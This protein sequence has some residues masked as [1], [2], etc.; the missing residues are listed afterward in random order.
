MGKFSPSQSSA[1]SYP[2]APCRGCVAGLCDRPLPGSL[3]LPP[4]I[5]QPAVPPCWVRVR[6][7]G[8]VRALQREHLPG[9]GRGA[10]RGGRPGGRGRVARTAA[11]QCLAGPQGTN[12]QLPSDIPSQGLFLA[13][14]LIFRP[15]LGVP[16]RCCGAAG[17]AYRFAMHRSSAAEARRQMRW[18]EIQ[19]AKKHISTSHAVC[20]DVS[21]TS[22]Q[23]ENMARLCGT[24]CR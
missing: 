22:S 11:K 19:G 10:G 5:C 21:G 13:S 1:C 16:P 8:G 18:I 3:L 6:G 12:F 9:G 14:E 20:L 2:Q 15:E 4:G 24:C 17:V 23:Q 7:G